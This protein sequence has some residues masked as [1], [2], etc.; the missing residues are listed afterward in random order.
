[1]SLAQ[2]PSEENVSMG[3]DLSTRSGIEIFYVQ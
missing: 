1:M 3:H 2:V